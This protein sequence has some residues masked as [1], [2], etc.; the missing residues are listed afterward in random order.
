M[1]SSAEMAAVCPLDHKT[2]SVMEST[3]VE[4]VQTNS[5]VVGTWRKIL[6]LVC[7][8]VE[9][10]YIALTCFMFKKSPG[11]HLNGSNVVKIHL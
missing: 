3:I 10:A 6:V 5:I 2:S 9:A 7:N 4:M 8:N 11:T 1:N